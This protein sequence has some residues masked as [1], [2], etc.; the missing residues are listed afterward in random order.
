MRVRQIERGRERNL[1]RI[2]TNDYGLKKPKLKADLKDFG[3]E[4]IECSSRSF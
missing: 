2:N 1:I 4:K 3:R